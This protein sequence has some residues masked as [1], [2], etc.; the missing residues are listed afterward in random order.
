MVAQAHDVE[1]ARRN[2]S[3][4]FH[5]RFCL[6]LAFRLKSVRCKNTTQPIYRA[7]SKLN[8]TI[9][10][11]LYL[12]EAATNL[13]AQHDVPR[14]LCY[15]TLQNFLPGFFRIANLANTK[16]RDSECQF[17]SVGSR[18]HF[19]VSNLVRKFEIIVHS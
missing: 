18:W 2:S 6:I 9:Q 8:I 11:V 5:S 15:A 17:A 4:T 1:P 14:V 7:E 10:Y 12:F 13:K 3:S 19:A 16:S